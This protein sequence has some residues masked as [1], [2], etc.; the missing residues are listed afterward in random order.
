[1]LVEESRANCRCLRAKLL[2]ITS[3]SGRLYRDRLAINLSIWKTCCRKKQVITGGGD[4]EF[5]SYMLLFS[6]VSSVFV[7]SD[8]W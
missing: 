2:T 3:E 8:I 5:F 7:H 6:V 4:L 1:M